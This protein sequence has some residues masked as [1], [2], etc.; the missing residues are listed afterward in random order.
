[1]IPQS[2]RPLLARPLRQDWGA[3]LP[4][5]TAADAITLA[6]HGTTPAVVSG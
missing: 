3:P 6:R 5:P 1:V 2:R 4:T